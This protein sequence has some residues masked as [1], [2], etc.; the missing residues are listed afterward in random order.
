MCKNDCLACPF[1]FFSDE[2]AQ[3]QN[4]GCLPTPMEIRDM[5]TKLDGV[6]GCHATSIEDGNLEPCVGFINWMKE[7][8]TPIKIK[9]KEL[10]DYPTWYDDP[11]YFKLKKTS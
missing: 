7:K 8:G 2:S 5:Y 10:I 4:Y 11:D 9:G 3:A 1:D 6:W